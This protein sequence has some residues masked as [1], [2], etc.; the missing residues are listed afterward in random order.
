MKSLSDS[1]SSF[2]YPKRWGLWLKPRAGSSLV[3]ISVALEKCQTLK[4]INRS[5][6][7]EDSTL[8]K[9]MQ[10]EPNRGGALSAEKAAEGLAR[11]T[12]WTYPCVLSPIRPMESDRESR[13]V[14]MSFSVFQ[15]ASLIISVSQN[16]PVTGFLAVWYKPWN[17]MYLNCCS[18]S[19]KYGL[20]SLFCIGKT[21]DIWMLDRELISW[22]LWYCTVKG[23]VMILSSLV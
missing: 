14:W 23:D 22:H 9:L 21:T 1:L 6:A 15:N 4:L 11:R 13:A 20:D 5:E 12:P 2:I 10:G 16:N 7:E 19:S 8:W 17:H 3:W 18:S